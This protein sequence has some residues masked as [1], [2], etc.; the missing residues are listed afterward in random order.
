MQEYFN[1]DSHMWHI[2]AIMYKKL[3]SM[4]L[5][6]LTLNF[7]ETFINI[8]KLREYNNRRIF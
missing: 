7:F 2:K 1:V 6:N 8:I 4:S 5:Q 3:I